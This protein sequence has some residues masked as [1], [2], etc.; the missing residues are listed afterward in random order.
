MATIPTKHCRTFFG[1]VENSVTAWPLYTATT[2][3]TTVVGIHYKLSFRAHGLPGVVFWGIGVED[4][5]Q[6]LVPAILDPNVNSDVFT[7]PRNMMHVDYD[8]VDSPRFTATFPW[9]N[10]IV[11]AEAA[12]VC[13]ECEQKLDVPLPESWKGNTG[14]VRTRRLIEPGESLILFVR[15]NRDPPAHG[16]NTVPEFF[17]LVTFWTL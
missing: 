12:P 8:L 16:P 2:K 15:S 5:A 13:G 11:V 17:A 10:K 9:S 3:R 14:S 7:R 4:P 6:G 1:R